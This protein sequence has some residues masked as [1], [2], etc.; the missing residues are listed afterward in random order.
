MKKLCAIDFNNAFSFAMPFGRYKGRKMGLL[1][2]KY[3]EWCASNLKGSIKARA[4][5]I[6]SC[7]ETHG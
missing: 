6:L 4:N 5:I 7:G 1:P 3:L 2:K